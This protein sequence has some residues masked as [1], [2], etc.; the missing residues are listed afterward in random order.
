MQTM[1]RRMMRDGAQVQ[2]VAIYTRVSTG[3]QTTENQRLALDTMAA[4]RGWTV[5]GRY[6]DAGISG[7]KTK[8]PAL[9]AL[10]ADARH[11]KFDAVLSWSLDRMGRSLAHL[12]D[13][14]AELEAA[15]VHVAF[16]QHSI[17]TTG[18][19][20]RLFLHMLGSFAQFEREMIRERV[21]AGLDRARAKGKRLGRP[22]IPAATERAVRARLTA[23]AGILKV[24]RELGVGSSVVQRIKAEMAEPAT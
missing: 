3:S 18:P 23:G 6:E 21:N 11:G 2:R 8:R 9:D 17:D 16:H 20:G 22:K 15:G 5:T 24:A 1:A 10:L 19:S 13:L 4:Q 14:V 12:I 7:A